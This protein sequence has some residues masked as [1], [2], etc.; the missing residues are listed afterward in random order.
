MITKNLPSVPNPLWNHEENLSIC[1]EMEEMKKITC[2][3]DIFENQGK[4]NE[5]IGKAEIDLTDLVNKNPKK[6][7]RSWHQI[8]DNKNKDLGES[9]IES[10]FCWRP[11]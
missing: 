3:I 10:E 4:T 9:M 8:K 1:F 5:C 7:F 2:T 6:N 11:R